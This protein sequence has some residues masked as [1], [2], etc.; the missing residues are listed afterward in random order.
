M[1]RVW[2]GA[3]LVPVALAV[4]F[5]F[6]PPE[7]DDAYHHTISAIEQARAW[8]EGAILPRYHRGWNGGTGSFAPTIYSPI[9]LSVQGGLAWAVGDGRRAVGF[10]LAVALLMLSAALVFWNGEPIAALAALTPYAMAVA[11]SRSTTTEAWALAGAATVLSLAMPGG[12]LTRRRGLGLA[13]GVFWVAGCQVGMLV[14]LGWLLGAAWA[15]ALIQHRKSAHN[16]WAAAVGSLGG[17]VGWMVAGLLSAAVLWLP[18]VVDARNLAVSELVSGPLDWRHNFLPGAS[19]LGVL[20][21]ATA[22]S[23]LGIAVIVAARGE[24]GNRFSL[25]AAV[26]LGV[27]LSTPLSAP[28]WH[29]PKMKI[30]QF[31][32]RFLGPA[33]LVAVIAMTGLRGRWRTAAIVLLILPLTLLPIRIGTESEVIPTRSTPQ[34]LAMIAHQQWGLAPILPSARGFYSNGFD[35]VESLGRLRRQSAEIMTIGRNAGGGSW[36][37]A[38]HRPGSVLLPLQWWPEWRITVDAVD[39]GYANQSGLVAVDLDRGAFEVRA[40]LE[41]SDSRCVAVP[42]SI[43]G[44]AALLFLL[45]ARERGRFPVSTSAAGGRA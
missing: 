21:T 7:G 44:I 10:S 41:R 1:K 28:L 25:A 43:G 8:H 16:G 14:Q 27:V 20:L 23:L 4:L 15:V 45:S 26:V 29:L 13:V 37:V 34:Q 19:Q 39:V 30:L 35:R 38:T 6:C 33:T 24:G 36:R 12:S 22:V 11:V 32:W 40:S 9:P 3:L 2:F 5:W 18:A 42:L 31:P 17:V